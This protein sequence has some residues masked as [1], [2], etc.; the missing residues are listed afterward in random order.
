MP[1][2]YMNPALDHPAY[3]ARIKLRGYNG[4]VT[5]QGAV[6]DTDSA[7]VLHRANPSW[8]KDEHLDLAQR[9]T[10]EADRLNNLHTRLLNQAH[11]ET[12]G[13]PP[14]ISDYRITAIGREEY[15]EEMKTQ[16]RQA[17][18]GYTAHAQASRGHRAAARR[19]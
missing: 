11:M 12:F 4:P 6:S 18:Y 15:P 8:S 10:I 17:A 19:S 1:T 2:S 16:L 7:R 5:F 14:V 9:H 13:R 3:S